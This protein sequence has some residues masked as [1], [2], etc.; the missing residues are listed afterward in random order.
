MSHFGGEPRAEA[1][2]ATLFSKATSIS[3]AMLFG[4]TRMRAMPR[5]PEDGSDRPGTS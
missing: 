1:R 5:S 2:K 3:G 4:S